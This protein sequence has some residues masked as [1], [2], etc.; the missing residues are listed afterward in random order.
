[1]KFKIEDYVYFRDKYIYKMKIVGYNC[2]VGSKV[3][4]L[5]P[6]ED[7][8]TIRVKKLEEN[9][10]NTLDE[11]I[12]NEKEKLKNVCNDFLEKEEVATP[13]ELSWIIK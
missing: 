4:T 1:M 2:N 7:L 13:L 12:E 11:L 5:I 8:F 3:Y 10:F 9:L 6:N